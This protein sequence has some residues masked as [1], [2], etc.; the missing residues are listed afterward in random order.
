MRIMV[1]LRMFVF[2]LT[3]I[4]LPV[5]RTSANYPTLGGNDNYLFYGSSTTSDISVTSYFTLTSSLSPY[6]FSTQVNTYLRGTCSGSSANYVDYQSVIRTNTSNVNQF[7]MDYGT[8][9]SVTNY[10]FNILTGDD[11]TAAGVAFYFWYNYNSNNQVTSS[12]VQVTGYGSCGCGSDTFIIY[13]SSIPSGA[14]KVTNEYQTILVGSS[15]QNGGTTT[16]TAGSGS[17]D[18]WASLSNYQSMSGNVYSYSGETSNSVYGTT[19]YYVGGGE[20]N[21]SWSY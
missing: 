2:L 1:Q 18:Y 13:V 5:L 10:Y 16:F 6:Q 20:Y 7:S 15:L 19:P 21:Q 14:N 3:L 9:T 4:V 17:I 11:L 8:C 12:E